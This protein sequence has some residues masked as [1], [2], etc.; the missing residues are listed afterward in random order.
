[1][2]KTRFWLLLGALL[3][4][5]GAVNAA[6]TDCKVLTAGTDA[7]FTNG[8]FSPCTL[9]PDGRLR[10]N[11]SSAGPAAAGTAAS[12]ANL[13]GGIYRSGG[14]SLTDGQQAAA[15]LSAT[16]RL[17]VETGGNVADA[18]A[19]S[20]NPT[21]VGAVYESSLPTY[22]TGQRTTLHTNAKG[23]L[24]VTGTDTTGAALGFGSGSADGQASAT[25]PLTPT[26]NRVL[27]AAGTWDRLRGSTQG[28]Y[29]VLVPDSD[30]RVAVSSAQSASA[31]SSV[32]A[33][34]SA[35]NLYGLTGTAAATPLWFMV[36]NATSAPVDGSVT[37]VRC[38][39][40]P[41]N[42]TVNVAFNPPIRF[43]TGITIVASSTGCFTQTLNTTGF[44]SAQYQ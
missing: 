36:D 3:L 4:L 20:G 5:D 9:S 38:V 11:H 8:D 12:Y 27:N 44:I 13:F 16:G 7:S 41:A 18:T 37:P 39:Y 26:F 40:A 43:S 1:M 25:G 29:A 6:V 31:V 10:V 14:I 33:K 42:S 32:V 21:K 28:G 24:F 30:S 22:T 23:I 34:A 15:S 2:T 17:Q 35:G 19:D